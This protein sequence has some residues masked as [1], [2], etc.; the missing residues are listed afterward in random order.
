[1][2][3][4]GSEVRETHCVTVTEMLLFFMMLTRRVR[5]IYFVV[6]FPFICVSCCFV[7]L[8]SVCGSFLSG[9]EAA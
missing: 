9:I 8:H 6:L 2:T 4:K 1:M 5:I 7:D 3:R